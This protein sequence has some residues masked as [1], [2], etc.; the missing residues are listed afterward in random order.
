MY[1]AHNLKINF[2]NTQLYRP[3]LLPL[4]LERVVMR[5][6]EGRGKVLILRRIK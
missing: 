4:L 2:I 1:L 3:L 6:G 5:W